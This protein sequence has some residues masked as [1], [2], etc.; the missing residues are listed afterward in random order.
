MTIVSAFPGV[1]VV[2]AEQKDAFRDFKCSTLE[3]QMENV[4]QHRIIV[5]LVRAVQILSLLST[6]MISPQNYQK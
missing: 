4:W 5:V 1:P 6:S 2:L 3:N